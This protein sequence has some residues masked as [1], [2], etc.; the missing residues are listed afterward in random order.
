MKGVTYRRKYC[1]HSFGRRKA[2]MPRLVRLM[3]TMVLLK[4]GLAVMPA[5]AQTV[6]V[7][8]GVTSKY[9]YIGQGGKGTL[10]SIRAGGIAI[11]STVTGYN[12]E[13]D[14]W[15]G[16]L[17][18]A[19]NL[20]S[21]GIQDLY[22]GSALQTQVTSGGSETIEWGGQATSTFVGAGGFAQI[23]GQ[24]T[25]LNTSVSDTV[26]GGS[27]AVAG[28]SATF[29]VLGPSA[30]ASNTQVGVGGYEI[31]SSGGI[32]TDTVVSSGGEQE[33]LSSGSAVSANILSGG[34]QYIALGGTAID[35]QVMSS[36]TQMIAAG[37]S[38]IDT[39]LYS[40]AIQIVSAGDCQR[41]HCP[42]RF[43]H[44]D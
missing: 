42:R 6:S 32:S 3:I 20:T 14:V 41:K 31:I 1:V 35:T 37:G 25:A 27:A 28:Q 16:G 33:I 5:M 12:Y 26:S 36:G 39:T 8:S 40:G 22:G 23:Y 34:S 4:A 21:H 13:E 2:R 29:V 18:S 7:T 38:S 43:R 9:D 19:A 24:G 11:S 15:G 30:Y 10:E 17:A 44:D